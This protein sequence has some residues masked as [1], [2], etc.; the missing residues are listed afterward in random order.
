MTPALQQALTQVNQIV[1]GKETQVR[2]CLARALGLDFH[3][4]QFTS[5]L[6]PAD[7]VAAGGVRAEYG[8]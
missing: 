8:A 6:L 7:T 5:D 2:L 3:R 1:L 4:P